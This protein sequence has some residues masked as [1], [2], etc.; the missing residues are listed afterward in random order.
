MARDISVRTGLRPELCNESK[1]N[2]HFVCSAIDKQAYHT[3][4]TWAIP[5]LDLV[6]VSVGV[7]VGVWSILY[8]HFE[9]VPI[10]EDS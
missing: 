2:H 10:I 5:V 9:I 7:S 4:A 8:G 3:S 1:T 6:L